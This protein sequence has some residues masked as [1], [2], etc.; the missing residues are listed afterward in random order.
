[1]NGI[2][3]LALLA[4]IATVVMQVSLVHRRQCA[5]ITQQHLMVRQ[6]VDR[7]EE[8]LTHERSVDLLVGHLHTII[9][10]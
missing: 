5:N 7:W 1:M 6:R 10:E 9:N 2:L 3:A 8:S 4:C